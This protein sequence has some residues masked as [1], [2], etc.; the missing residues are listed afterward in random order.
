MD[1]ALSLQIDRVSL[2]IPPT[3]TFKGPV[4][5]HHVGLNS[6]TLTMYNPNYSGGDQG[7]HGYPQ[8]P[9][10]IQQLYGQSYR[11]PLQG[12]GYSG[13]MQPQFSTQQQPGL[14]QGQQT[15]FQPQATNQSSFQA[16]Q[17]Y[18]GGQPYQQQAQLGVQAT[19]F[20]N[21]ASP[22]YMGGSSATV[23]LQQQKTGFSTAVAQVRQ[24]H[25]LKIP[26]MR[27]SFIT[28]ADQSKFEDLFRTAVP[29]GESAISGDAARDILLRSGLP[30]VTLAEIWALCDTNKLGL[31]LFPEFALA[32]SMC[33]SSLKGEPMLRV[34]PE[35]WLNEVQSFVDAISFAVPEDPLKVLENTPFSSFGAPRNLADDFLSGS[36][37]PHS[38][39]FTA[40]PTGGFQ[41]IPSLLQQRT[42]G[43]SLIPLQPQQT[44]GLVPASQVQQPQGPGPLAAQGT[45][46]DF[47][48]PLA[49]Q[50]TGL[51]PLTS[52]TTQ[53]TGG[54]QP[55][56]PNSFLAQA[57]GGFQPQA[58]DV[59]SAQGTYFSMHPQ[60]TGFQPQTTGYQQPG[61]QQQVTGTLQTPGIQR[62]G[63]GYQLA[64]IQ[65]QRTGQ[66]SFAPLQAQPTGKPGEWGFVSMPTGGLPGLNAMQQHF[67]PSSQLPSNNL[68]N[69]MGGQLKDNVGWAITKQEKQIYDGIF[70]AW[71]TGRKGY[72][73]GDVAI[74]IFGKSGLSRPDLETVWNLCDSSNRGKLNKDEFAVAMH[75]VYRR[76]NGL[77]LPLRLPPELVPPSAKLLQDSVDSLKSSLKGGSASRNSPVNSVSTAASRFKNDDDDIPYVSSSRYKSHRSGEAV[78][79]MQTSNNKELEIQD[80]KK[81]IR[82][83]RI[84]LDAV[85]LEDQHE[86]IAMR[87][88]ES[89]NARE[90]E[91]LKFKIKAVQ[92]Q[93]SQYAG[94]APQYERVNL[95]K[96]LDSYTKD[97]VPRLISKISKVNTDIANTKVKL[98]EAHLKQNYPS[99]APEELEDSIAGTGTNG[100]VTDTDRRKFRSKQL[101]QKRMAALTG[102]SVASRA[103]SDA[104]KRWN[105]EVQNIKAESESQALMVHDVLASIQELEEGAVVPLQ[106]SV[107]S[108][109]V[110]RK[111]EQGEGVL[112]PVKAFI[113]ELNAILQPQKS[114]QKHQQPQSLQQQQVQKIQLQKTKAQ[115]FQQNQP[116][117]PVEPKFASADERSAYVKASAGKRMQE[118]LAKLKA[119]RTK[120]L[121][122]MAQVESTKPEAPKTEA[123]EQPE[124][125]PKPLPKPLPESQPELPKVEQA[126]ELEDE[127]YAALLKEKQ[128]LEEKKKERELKRNRDKEA[129]LEKLRK[130]MEALKASDNDGWSDDDLKALNT[131]SSLN[132]NP[133][134]E[135]ESE[136]VEAKSD[137][138]QST[139]SQFFP[140]AQVQP[141]QVQPQNDRPAQ[142]QIDTHAQEVYAGSGVHK[143]NPFTKE[144]AAGKN[145]NPFFKPS[146][147]ATPVDPKKLQNQ[148]AAQRGLDLSGW[149]DEEDNSSD[150]EAPNRAGAAKLA[151]LLF[152]GMPQPIS[153][154]ATGVQSTISKTGSD[155]SAPTSQS[156]P[157]VPKV[158]LDPVSAIEAPRVPPVPV[159]VP[160]QTTDTSKDSDSEDQFATP[161]PDFGSAENGVPPLPTDSVPPLSTGDVPPPLPTD[162][163]PVVI[164]PPPIPNDIPPPPLPDQAPPPTF[165][166]LL[167]VPPAP[168]PPSPPLLGVT[169][170]TPSGGMP[171]LGALLGQIQGGKSLK[172]VS[173]SEKRE[174]ESAVVGRVL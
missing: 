141:V 121:P 61:L 123:S 32:L 70:I 98:C 100:E 17:S 82:E 166:P 138:L 40:Q 21:Q 44:A 31:L 111:W 167:S 68:Q 51:L 153:R 136:T 96:T 36:V 65:A 71:D 159:E 2:P 170:T 77:E 62:Q 125:L 34:L 1:D 78:S 135:K 128:E 152:S 74:S 72:I 10:Q 92:Q 87:Q 55:Q 47:L 103:G 13:Q 102:K 122:S 158:P 46:Y 19:G 95:M 25:E 104:D 18:A 161:S 155:M 113:W 91:S 41:S 45:G 118:R 30:P 124:P 160:S 88:A 163:V 69:Q 39:S 29:V 57:T 165:P 150:E 83:K 75:L 130:E 4:F 145:T 43:G 58:S 60:G 22:P 26:S 139:D 52:F 115:G 151:S 106:I 119:L 171:N 127:E 80:L 84:L 28:A 20:N 85:N 49:A 174:S 156:M 172:K 81:L 114:Q 134:T 148:R 63:T 56:P 131:T 11:L 16:H 12:T 126:D 15:G 94:T 8:Q 89:A 67:L 116:T 42:G 146:S 133:E 93:L 24:N 97:M 101:L 35:K 99:W 164:A 110:I 14:F 173:D 86:A 154:N 48:A 33:N 140:S 120:S 105:E 143:S 6:S 79:S 142:S 109:A 90:I 168:G 76:L 66:N 9:Q 107:K 73:E 5:S 59:G 54:F 169:S 7:N 38:T 53:L 147:T 108:E 117:A 162:S 27:L 144:A 157:Q 132:A 50:R 129:R 112:E 3:L 149:S 64:P 23:P 137:T 37:A